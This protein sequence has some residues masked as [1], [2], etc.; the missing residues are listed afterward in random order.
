M[1]KRCIYLIFVAKSTVISK[2]T[3]SAMTIMLK[4]SPLVT[5]TE[6]IPEFIYTQDTFSIRTRSFTPHP[7]ARKLVKSRPRSETNNEWRQHSKL[8][9]EKCSFISFKGVVRALPRCVCVVG[10]GKEV[11]IHIR[12]KERR[13]NVLFQVL[14]VESH[15]LYT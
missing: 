4:V 11:N 9:I 12:D 6:G 14:N 3:G 7:K 1:L 13:R 10:T 5:Y 2:T 15:K 8:L